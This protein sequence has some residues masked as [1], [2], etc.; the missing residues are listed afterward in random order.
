MV[1][2]YQ[3]VIYFFETFLSLIVIFQQM[4]YGD[5]LG[6]SW[7]NF[8]SLDV[9]VYFDCAIEIWVC[10]RV[11]VSNCSHI[12]KRE[13]RY[14]IGASWTLCLLLNVPTPIVEPWF[15]C[16]FHFKKKIIIKI[17]NDKRKRRRRKKKEKKEK[18]WKEGE[19]E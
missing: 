18:S 2:F 1:E 5:K 15:F 17:K 4:L 16:G 9:T 10:W 8:I 7:C 14:L 19:E 13:I 12:A 11:T 6:L 3:T